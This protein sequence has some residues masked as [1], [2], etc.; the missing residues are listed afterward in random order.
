MFLFKTRFKSTTWVSCLQYQISWTEISS[1]K[2]SHSG[3]QTWWETRKM[4]ELEKISPPSW[5][6][7]RSSGAFLILEFTW[8]Y[9]HI[10]TVIS[11][12]RFRNRSIT[13]KTLPLFCCMTSILKHKEE[14]AVVL[15]C[16][17]GWAPF[18]DSLARDTESW[19]LI[20][21]DM[22]SGTVFL[23]YLCFCYSVSDKSTDFWTRIKWGKPTWHPRVCSIHERIRK[24]FPAVQD[25]SCLAIYLRQDLASICLFLAVFSRR[26]SH[27]VSSHNAQVYQRSQHAKFASKIKSLLFVRKW[28]AKLALDSHLHHIRRRRQERTERL[29]QGAKQ[30]SQSHQERTQHE[31]SR[32]RRLLG[33]LR[34]PDPLPRRNHQF[35]QK[36]RTLN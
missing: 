20:F 32:R 9:F 16:G 2:Q 25:N 8:N 30:D 35:C 27:S 12:S 24:A 33:L 3:L 4:S 15:A 28:H 29:R 5:I 18:I 10:S 7:R 26:A 19:V 6:T 13:T 22:D 14:P 36:D 11:E 34:W 31:D 1:S 21:P 23:C 17:F